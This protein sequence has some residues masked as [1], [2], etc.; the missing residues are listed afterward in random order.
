MLRTRAGK[1]APIGAIPYFLVKG[2]EHRNALGGQSVLGRN[3][4]NKR[5]IRLWR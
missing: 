5:D 2:S 3:L 1:G 4:L